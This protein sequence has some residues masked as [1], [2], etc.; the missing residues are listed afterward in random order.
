MISR[1]LDIKKLTAQYYSVFLF[2]PRGVG[3]SSLLRSL[4]NVG[5]HYDLLNGEVSRALLLEPAQFRAQVTDLIKRAAKDSPVLVI[6][7][8]VQLAPSILNEVHHLI[9]RFPE[10]IVFLLTGSS[11]RKLKREGANMLA[12]RAVTKKLFPVSL[13]ETEIDLYRA[14]QF[15]TLPRP[16]FSGNDPKPYLASYVDTYLREE[17]KQESLVRKIDSFVRFLDLAA[18]LNGENINFSKIGRQCG[19]ASTTIQQYYSILEDTLIVER[20]DGWSETVKKQ[21][22]LGPRYYFFD[23]G[24]LNSLRRELHLE[25]SSS[26]FRFGKLFETYMVN[27]VRAHCSYLEL[28]YRFHYWRT[29][30][31]LEVDLILSRS[32]Y[33]PPLAIEFKSSTTPEANE[34]NGLKAFKEENPSAK[35]FCLCRTSA[36]YEKDGILF[37]P[38]SELRTIFK[39]H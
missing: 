22:V 26:S 25:L 2:G 17:I 20:V 16:Y 38:W 18:Q 23:C 32:S 27:E 13:S 31:G 1:A 19:V 15:G 30:S 3:K 4:E 12:G 29:N 36:R 37:L 11:S 10:K 8:E 34:L 6:L 24:I 7:D 39:S 33:D 9:E 5:L 28:D 21:L 35:L 14:L